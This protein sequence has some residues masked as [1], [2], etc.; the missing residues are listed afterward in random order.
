MRYRLLRRMLPLTIF[1]LVGCVGAFAAYATTKPAKKAT[2]VCRTRQRSTKAHPCLKKAVA[3]P[4]TTTT[5]KT[6]TATTTTTTAATT[7]TTAATP[8]PVAPAGECPA[9][10]TIPQGD[11]A[12][13]GD[14]DNRDFS[15]SDADGCI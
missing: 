11:G 14:S 6:T 15:P 9:G 5:T 2:P 1:L 4:K 7:T 3:K 12:G 10:Q 8:A 13:D